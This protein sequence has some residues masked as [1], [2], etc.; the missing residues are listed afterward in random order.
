MYEERKFRPLT[1]CLLSTDPITTGREELGFC[2]LYAELPD[3]KTEGGSRVHT[4][5]WLGKE[6]MHLEIPGLVDTD[7]QAAPARSPR[8]WGHRE[9]LSFRS[10]GAEADTSFAQQPNRASCTIAMSLPSEGLVITTRP[11]RHTVLLRLASPT[12]S[13]IKRPRTLTLS[14]LTSP[15]R[16]SRSYRPS[17]MWWTV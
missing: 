7:T 12:F 15:R 6:F 13:R 5:S 11:T 17:G 1:L 10:F 16:L 2:K 9:L 3:G 8:S 14:S 4:A